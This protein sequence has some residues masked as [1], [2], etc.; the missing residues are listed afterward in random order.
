M[1]ETFFQACGSH[2]VIGDTYSEVELQP[3][4]ERKTVGSSASHIH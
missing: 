3:N 4:V 1:L 2:D